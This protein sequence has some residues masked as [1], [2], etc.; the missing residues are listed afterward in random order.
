M[1]EQTPL[2]EATAPAQVEEQPATEQ[3]VQ[4][5]AEQPTQPVQPVTAEMLLQETINR[6]AELT[7]GLAD[8]RRELAERERVYRS[9][10]AELDSRAVKIEIDEDACARLRG[11]MDALQALVQGQGGA[12]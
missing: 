11:A 5:T 2:P 6:L 12:Q 1:D 10:A 4:P 3:P 7:L 8:K 9:I